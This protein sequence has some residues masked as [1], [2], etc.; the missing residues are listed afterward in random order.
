MS[1]ITDVILVTALGDGDSGE[2][3]E[4][5]NPNVDRLNL[6]LAAQP[7]NAGLGLLVKVNE[8][9]R[10]KALQCDVFVTAFNYL[11]I[12]KFVALFRSIPWEFPEQAQLMLKDENDDVFNS[13]LAQARDLTIIRLQP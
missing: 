2:N 9:T 8:C 6:W 12:D 1:H 13:Y 7:L 4:R 3:E 5:E 11:D 10:G